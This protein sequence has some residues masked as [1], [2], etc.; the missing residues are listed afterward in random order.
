M[1]CH[2]VLLV[3]FNS[4]QKSSLQ[5]QA[6]CSNVQHPT[7]AVIHCGET[8]NIAKR[9]HQPPCCVE[10]LGRNLL[11]VLGQASLSHS[12]W[13]CLQHSIFLPA[14]IFEMRSSNRM[15]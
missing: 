8:K 14:E 13:C 6:V 3:R 2:T 9:L 1:E 4:K 10:W 5:A 7:A 11:N 15:L 12:S